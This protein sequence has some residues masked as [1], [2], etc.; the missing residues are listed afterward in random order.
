MT[1]MDY[2]LDTDCNAWG[3]HSI[4]KQGSRCGAVLVAKDGRLYAL[5]SGELAYALSSLRCATKRRGNLR[6]HLSLCWNAGVR[7]LLL[8]QLTQTKRAIGCV[9]S[10]LSFI[11]RV[12]RVAL[13]KRCD[14]LRRRGGYC[15]LLPEE[16]CPRAGD[17][18]V[19]D[20]PLMQVPAGPPA[21]GQMGPRGSCW[22][23]VG[24]SALAYSF[25][26]DG[27]GPREH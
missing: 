9:A 6:P 15:A 7:L 14:F 13:R 18:A 2:A 24:Y 10:K 20:C 19:G 5:F 3:I 16:F 21:V 4:S 23:R 26:T 1:A 22:E 27:Q 11:H 17:L 25:S 8:S 12:R